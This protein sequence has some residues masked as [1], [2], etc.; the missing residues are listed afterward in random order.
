MRII[1]VFLIA[2][3]ATM[4]E[5][6]D[7]EEGDE[8]G[9][10]KNTEDSDNGL[11]NGVLQAF[12]RVSHAGQGVVCNTNV[13]VNSDSL[14]FT[15]KLFRLSSSVSVGFRVCLSACLSTC[16]PA[17]LSVCLPVCLSVCLPACLPV[18]L[19]VRLSV[20]LSVCL[21]LLS[22]FLFYFCRHLLYRR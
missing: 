4:T 12:P 8:E 16:L 20:C 1:H 10:E 5:D 6:D 18:C 2:T 15:H 17:C 9:E 21:N 7:A 3:R 22:L 19:Y 11:Q 13:S 14:F